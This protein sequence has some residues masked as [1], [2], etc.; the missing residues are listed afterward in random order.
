VKGFLL[1]TVALVG[2]EALL[3]STYGIDN[4]QKG[5]S[6]FGRGLRRLLAPDVAGVPNKNKPKVV[7]GNATGS[8][9]PVP[10]VTNPYIAQV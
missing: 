2:L 3:T 7:S 1:G 6:L 8:S 4:L 9:Y 10:T 5:T